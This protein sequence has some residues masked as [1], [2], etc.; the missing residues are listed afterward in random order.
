MFIN[1]LS[2]PAGF[3]SGQAT[4]VAG[5]GFDESY[6]VSD[7][8]SPDRIRIRISGGR[9]SGTILVESGLAGTV[10]VMAHEFGHSLGLPDLY[11]RS[12]MT[13]AHDGP[14]DDSAGIGAWGLMGRGALGWN[15]DGPSAMCTWSREQLGWVGRDNE[16][17]VEVEEN[18][19]GLEIADLHRGGFIYKVPLRTVV[20]DERYYDEEYLLLEHRVRSSNYY[21]RN[22]PGEGLLVWHVQP[23]AFTNNVEERKLVDLVCADGLYG[24]GRIAEPQSGRDDLDFWSRDPNYTAV[25][26]G[27]LGDATDPFDGTRLTDFAPESNPS[28]HL[29]GPFSPANTGFALRNMHRRGE[30]LIADLSV[31]RWSGVISGEVHWAGTIV[32]DGDLTIAPEGR[33]VIYNNTRVLFAGSDG[34]RSGLDPDRIEVHVEGRLDFPQTQLVRFESN[35]GRWREIRTEAAVL[36]AREAGETWYGVGFSSSDLADDLQA[37]AERFVLRDAERGV[38]MDN[39]AVAG[40]PTAVAAVAEFAAERTELLANYPN[41]SNPETTIPYILAAPARIRLTVYDVLGQ[42]VGTLVDVDS[43][44]ANT[45]RRGAEWMRAAVRR[46]AGST[47]IAFK[48]P[49]SGRM[50]IPPFGGWLTAWG[51]YCRVVHVFLLV[52]PL[53]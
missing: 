18:V 41:P 21:N 17:L 23:H 9:N 7:D 47:S 10:G 44:P 14:A 38:F 20:R 5:L 42:A 3:I 6:D 52:C 36:Q 32:V 25:N 48:W 37:A 50:E 31:P 29:G 46:P 11:D 53:L 34:L 4:G 35:H 33:L 45:G 51:T 27:N 15:N 30:V 16:R 1:L 13:T 49:A 19:N 24:P 43:R 8:T 2:A 12:F 22:L 39:G 26:G 28:S 40:V